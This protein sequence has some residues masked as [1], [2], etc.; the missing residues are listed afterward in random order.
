MGFIQAIS[1]F[2]G[3]IF[4]KS[5][6]ESQKK[7]QLKKLDQELKEYQPFLPS[8]AAGALITIGFVR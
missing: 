3:A 4:K 1:D 8:L 7:Q 2:F 5:S 6:P